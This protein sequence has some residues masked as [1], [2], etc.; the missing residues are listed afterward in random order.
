MAAPNAW[1]MRAVRFLVVDTCDSAWVFDEQNRRFRR[2]L[3]GIDA[4]FT[5]A[6]E[7]RSYDHLL[8]DGG[9]D[10]FLVYIDPSGRRVLRARRH[11]EEACDEC[12]D[13]GGLGMSQE[14]LGG[15]LERWSLGASPVLEPARAG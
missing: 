8:I 14:S 11:V 10:R 7:W 4:I 5:F 6:T 9:S 12:G 3:K 15:F 2:L 1:E 13:I